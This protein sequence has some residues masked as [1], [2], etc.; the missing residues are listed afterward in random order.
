MIAG[1]DAAIATAQLNLSYCYHHRRRSRAGSA[2]ARS[3]PATWC[4]PPTR[5][6]S[7]TIT[8]IHP[9][10]V[11]FT[12]PQ[13]DPA[14]RSTLAMAARKLPVTACHRDGRTELDQGTL[15][16]PDNAIDTDAPARS[17]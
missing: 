6:G 16:T 7:C 5:P 3:I 9:I 12:L 15:L 14:A 17:S 8:Q 11:L 1:D 4:T 2:C 10:A 13:D